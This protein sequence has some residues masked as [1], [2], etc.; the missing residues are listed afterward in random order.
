MYSIMKIRRRIAILAILGAWGLSTLAP[1]SDA[2]AG[3]DPAAIMKA[4]A[5]SRKLDNS[6]AVVKMR[7]VAKGGQARERKIAM[8]T[9]L[10]DGGKTEKR[11]YRFLEPA[12]VK[13]TG[14]LVVDYEDKADDVWI[15]LPALRKTRKVVSSERSKSFMGSEFSYGDLNIP[16]LKEY[17]FNLLGAEKVGGAD[18]WKIETLPKDPSTA[19][20]EGY[21]KKIFWIDKATHALLQGEFYDL[22]NKLQKKLVSRDVKLVDPAKKKYRTMKM[23]MTNVQDGRSS[24]FET[25]EISTKNQV[26]DEYF[27][28]AYL[29]RI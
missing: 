26:K 4:W 28:T 27:T 17:K 15:F 20:S 19:K 21:S 29:E 12:E 3:A 9:R 13:G 11:V 7:I 1:V 2:H 18:C 5:E 16:D 10:Y 8:A 14:V 23:E 6:E 24:T 25:T 22:S